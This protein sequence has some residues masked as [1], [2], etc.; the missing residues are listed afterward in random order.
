MPPIQY[1][2]VPLPPSFPKPEFLKWLRDKKGVQSL[3][4]ANTV[5]TSLSFLKAGGLV[6]RAKAEQD[7][8]PQTDQYTDVADKAYGIFDK[9]FVDPTDIHR[10]L[11]RRNLYGPVTFVFAVDVVA[12]ECVREVRVTRINPANWHKTSGQISECWFDTPAA[13]NGFEPTG[14]DNHIVLTCDAGLLPFGPHLQR[15]IL[16][17]PQDGS[18]AYDAAYAVLSTYIS[19]EKRTCREWCDCAKQYGRAQDREK[20]FSLT[21]KSPT[22][23]C[24]L[25]PFES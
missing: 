10:R 5:V 11:S 24:G 3:Y 15:V 12:M 8:L 9:I 13:L 25:H 2:A 18:D 19:I 22:N 4:H 6:S 20:V 17:D 23:E 16:D 1:P 21:P 7:Q 14:F